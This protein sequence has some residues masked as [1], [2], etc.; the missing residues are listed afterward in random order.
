MRTVPW[1]G[2]EGNICQANSKPKMQRFGASLSV[3]KNPP[4]NVGD[5]GLIPGPE[6][7]HTPWSN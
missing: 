2:T 3:I 5:M 4:T 7:S 1:V 6:E